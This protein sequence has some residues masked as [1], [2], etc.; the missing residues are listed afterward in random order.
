MVALFLVVGG[1]AVGIIATRLP[2]HGP[3]LSSQSGVTTP[4]NSSP[5]TTSSAGGAHTTHPTG[6]TPPVTST[7]AS[8]QSPSTHKVVSHFAAR[9]LPVHLTIPNLG[10]S[11]PL[12]SLG[13][14]R[15]GT[16][17]VPTDF[18]V[19]GWY[20]YGP[21][22]G[23]RGSAV[24]LGHV[25]SYKGPAVF[26][27]LSHLRPGDPVVVS[28]ADHAVVR[29]KVIGIREYSKSNFPDKIVYGMRPYSALQLV[30]CGGVFDRATG[31]YES[32]IVVY[33][34]MTSFTR[35]HR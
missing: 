3:S 14:N 22:P 24:I 33:T 25:D 27:Y 9:S 30:T 6:T 19:P 26:F 31:H 23:Q 8:N 29:F 2:A 21:T 4:S 34:T 12:T 15:D 5:T 28:L 35:P 17:S 32:N 1:I 16:V 18:A 13:L 11:V 10:V 20:R 7:L